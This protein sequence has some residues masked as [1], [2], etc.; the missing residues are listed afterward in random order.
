M[1]YVDDLLASVAAAATRLRKVSE[2]DAARRP[3]PGKWSA[4]EIIGHLID[5]AANNHQRFVRAVWQEDLVFPTY[6]QDAWVSSQG[7][8]SA[9]WSDLLDL[10]T[11]Y[12]YHLG[13]VM[14]ATPA[15]AR[16]RVHTRHNLDVVAWQS[17]PRAQTTSLDYLMRDYVGHLQHHLRQLD[18]LRLPGSA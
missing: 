2:A 1:E 18:A 10:W 7:Y 12:N 11:S 15:G 8:Q 14:R 5:S 6:D 17:V 9:S 13:H 16:T 3:R 4:K